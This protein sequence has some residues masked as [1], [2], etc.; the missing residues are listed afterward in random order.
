MASSVPGN[1]FDTLFPP[2]GLSSS[3]SASKLG[4]TGLRK[5]VSMLSSNSLH[6]GT[7]PLLVK[8]SGPDNANHEDSSSVGRVNLL[9]FLESVTVN[10]DYL[11]IKADDTPTVK[12][13]KGLN[14]EIR[15]LRAELD[16][17][18]KLINSING[19][20][21][22]L[23]GGV[24]MGSSWKDKVAPP[25]VSNTR[26]T[27]QYF[28]PTVEGD[29][30]TVSPPCA[31]EVKG[32]EKWKNCLVGHF[33]DKKIPFLAVRSVAFKKWTDYG[34]VDVLSND[35]GFYFFQFGSEGACREIVESGPWHF[36]GRLMVL[37][38]WHPDI[39]YEKEG[40]TKLPIWIQ[41]YNV[42]LQYWTAEGL[43]YLASSVGKPLYADEM[44][45][46]AKRISYAKICVEVDVNASLPH[47]VDLLMSSGKLVSIAIKY[48]WRP[49]KC[50]VMDSSVADTSDEVMGLKVA[51][52]C[53]DSG[54]LVIKDS[55]GSDLLGCDPNSSKDG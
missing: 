29:R 21:I 1:T 39:E 15:A 22:V 49:V 38:I 32:A 30:I 35:K 19:S 7:I 26:M 13:I 28:P 23:P 45:E 31:V 20:G 53:L 54:V 46:T 47:S 33:V 6:C 55:L 40:L 17:K 44:T 37:Q 5:P 43:S 12:Q 41:L 3:T 10:H 25:G 36:G 34:L 9:D 18:H 50:G 52:V 42:P 8:D 14:Q 48:P 4:F 2:L 11:E 51:D 24:E 27:F 16:S